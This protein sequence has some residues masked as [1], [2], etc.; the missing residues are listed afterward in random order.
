M[1]M[2]EDFGDKIKNLRKLHNLTQEELARKLEVSL[3]TVSRWER[4]DFVIPATK[5][6]IDVC[7]LFGVS[8]NYL[9]GIGHEH[10]IAIDMLSPEQQ[11]LLEEIV[12]VWQ[13]GKNSGRQNYTIQI[14]LEEFRK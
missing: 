8:M 11:N 4:G 7:L 2:F 13:E 10:A 14:L 1:T 6:L 12:I 5:N 3:S 9:A